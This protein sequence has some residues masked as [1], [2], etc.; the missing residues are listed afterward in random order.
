MITEAQ[1]KN[2]SH[3]RIVIRVTDKQNNRANNNN[4]F[5]SM[6]QHIKHRHTLLVIG[7]VQQTQ[8]ETRTKVT[9]EKRNK[10]KLSTDSHSC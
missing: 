7:G 6:F 9:T 8:P 5:C 4:R 2:Q 10:N 1:T 3:H